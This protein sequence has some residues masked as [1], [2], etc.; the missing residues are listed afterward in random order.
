MR[1]HW[2]GLLVFGAT[3]LACG[4]LPGEVVGTYRITMM[5]EDNSCG[6]G[7]INVLDGHRYS[8]ELRSDMK[9][10]Y[11][12]VPNQP[13][14]KGDYDAPNFSFENSSIVANEGPDAGPRGCSL[15]Q[16]DRLTGKLTELPDAGSD[17]D[18]DAETDSDDDAEDTPDKDVKLDAGSD[19]GAAEDAGSDDDDAA[20]RG[21]H[22]FTISAAAGS[23]CSSALTPR[24][25]FEKLPCTVR[26]A[27]RGVPIKPF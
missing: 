6:A 9:R 19:A 4:E 20:L 14:L 24:G 5:L 26:Y 11:W 12:H 1:A 25:P 22:T 21:E 18:E 7:A 15:R 3:A 2:L 13:P 10:G 23:N 17:D 27:V 8:V 16:V